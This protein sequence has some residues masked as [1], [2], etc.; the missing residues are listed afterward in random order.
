MAAQ[1]GRQTLGAI[2]PMGS[3]GSETYVSVSASPS[4]S[5]LFHEGGTMAQFSR[6]SP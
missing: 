5:A 2:T 4:L 3:Q 6:F 1:E